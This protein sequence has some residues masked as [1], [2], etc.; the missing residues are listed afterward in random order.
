MD[1]HVQQ[2][3]LRTKTAEG[4]ERLDG[5]FCVEFPPDAMTT[6]V[7][8]P[9]CPVFEKVPKIQVFPVDESSASLR[10]ISPKTFGV[11]VDVKRNDPATQR[12]RFAIVVEG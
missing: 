8:I 4:L 2:Q 10:I 11:R 6:T 3:M 12:L 5:T 1:E 9:F 7:H